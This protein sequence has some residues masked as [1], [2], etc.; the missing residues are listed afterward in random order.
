M[1]TKVCYVCNI[2]KDIDGFYPH[3]GM[4]DG[5]LNL[6]KECNK[7]RSRKNH[8]DNREDRNKK[9]NDRYYKNKEQHIKK[10]VEYR[11][12]LRRSNP[13]ARAM[14]ATRKRI[15]DACKKRGFPK[16]KKT[17]YLLGCDWDTFKTHIESKFTD[18]MTWE[19]YGFEKGKW[20]IDHEIPLK[21]ADSMDKLIKLTHYKNLQ[22]MW[23]ENNLKKGSKIMNELNLKF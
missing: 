13:L 18:G 3:K 15:W 12:N 7:D 9:R 16:N 4:K 19:I 11:R 17:N 22:P 5:R 23:S 2:E 8:N 21:I 1:V 20:H 10:N 14:D 6:C